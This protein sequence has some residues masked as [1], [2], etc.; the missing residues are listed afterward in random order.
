MYPSEIMRELIKDLDKVARRRETVK[1]KAARKF[2]KSKVFPVWDYEDYIVPESKNHYI[3]YYYAFR[4]EDAKNPEV[5]SCAVAFE[6]NNRVLIKGGKTLL[7][8]DEYMEIFILHAYSTHFLERY[9]ERISPDKKLNTTEAALRFFSRN[10]DEEYSPYIPVN[11]NESL[12]KR[13]RD[14]E[15]TAEYCIKM[16]EGISLLN[17]TVESEYGEPDK[18]RGLFFLHKTFLPYSLLKE[19]QKAA[20][21]EEEK[22]YWK[23]LLQL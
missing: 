12:L 3:I 4:R 16:K 20:L 5:H 7:R 18:V 23:E 10:T 14:Y 6:N 21:H 17:Q 11:I 8:K 9:A 15:Y 2:Q 13:F 22:K 1:S 19:T